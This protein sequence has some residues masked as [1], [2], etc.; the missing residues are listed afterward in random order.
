[1]IK[2]ELDLDIVVECPACEAQ[3]KVVIPVQI[4]H[5]GDLEVSEIVEEQQETDPDNEG[6]FDAAAEEDK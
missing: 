2:L 1:M 5:E 4:E 6:D 3:L